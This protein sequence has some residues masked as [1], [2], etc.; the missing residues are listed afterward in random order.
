MDPEAKDS[1]EDEHDESKEAPNPRAEA[2]YSSNLKNLLGKSRLTLFFSN[3]QA[4]DISG[5]NE[6]REGEPEAPKEAKRDSKTPKRSSKTF[7]HKKY[8]LFIH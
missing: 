4:E 5:E 2:V 3:K 8:A 7:A 6:K 1:V